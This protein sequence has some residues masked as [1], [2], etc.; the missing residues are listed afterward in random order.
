MYVSRKWRILAP[1]FVIFAKELI[2]EK[3]DTDGTIDDD[4]DDGIVAIDDD[5]PAVVDDI[6]EEENEDFFFPE[7]RAILF[8]FFSGSYFPA[9][10]ESFRVFNDRCCASDADEQ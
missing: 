10:Y 4:D 8:F 9:S 6:H 3:K 7:E 1:K 5:N 2:R